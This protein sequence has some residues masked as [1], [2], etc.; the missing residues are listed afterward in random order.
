MSDDGGGLLHNA[1]LCVESSPLCC[2]GQNQWCNL[3]E[4]TYTS[5]RLK[6]EQF[7]QVFIWGTGEPRSSSDDVKLPEPGGVPTSQVPSRE[8]CPTFLSLAKDLEPVMETLK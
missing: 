6:R 1:C 2:Q 7:H 3:V 8:I 5:I 4:C